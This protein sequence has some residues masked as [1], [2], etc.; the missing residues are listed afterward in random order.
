M[1]STLKEECVPFMCVTCFLGIVPT[2]KDFFSSNW[3]VC[4][5]QN[6]EGMFKIIFCKTSSQFHYASISEQPRTKAL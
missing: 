3:R 6:Q 1:I 4:V 2:P 5:D